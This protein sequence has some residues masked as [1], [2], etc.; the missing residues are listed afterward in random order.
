MLLQTISRGFRSDIPKSLTILNTAIL[1]R[2]YKT[3]LIWVTQDQ[4]QNC[5]PAGNYLFNVNNRNTRKRCQ[6]CSNLA[7]FSSVS[8]VNFE[9]VNVNQSSV[10]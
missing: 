1:K 3:V 7:P 4:P 6:I 8:I 2:S 5:I 9:Q 10:L